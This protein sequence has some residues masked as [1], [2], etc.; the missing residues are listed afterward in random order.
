MCLPAASSARY[1]RL[2][3]VDEANGDGY[4][5]VAWL[6]VW[7]PL[8]LTYGAEIGLQDEMIAFDGV[9]RSATGALWANRQRPLRQVSM[10]L[11]GSPTAEADALHE[12][13]RCA[14]RT[15]P[16]LY[17]PDLADRAAT[18]RY[19]F[20]GT[21]AELSAIEFPYPRHRHLPLR[22]TEYA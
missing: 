8:V 13:L 9:E 1:E 7:A 3:L 16:V 2:T 20:V 11:R 15:E 10:V 12:L 14:G 4:L 6:S 19:G 5:E 17:M 22:F 21:A 18:Q